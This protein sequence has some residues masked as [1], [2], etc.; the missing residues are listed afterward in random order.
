MQEQGTYTWVMLGVAGQ[1]HTLIGK[2]KHSE[3][4]ATASRTAARALR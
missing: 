2:A 3:G 4:L 1:R